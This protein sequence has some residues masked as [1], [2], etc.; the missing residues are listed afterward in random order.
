M[1]T[2]IETDLIF[3]ACTNTF[4]EF[5]NSNI[6]GGVYDPSGTTLDICKAVCIGNAK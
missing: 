4:Q 2:S 1:S 6:D 3:S 5:A